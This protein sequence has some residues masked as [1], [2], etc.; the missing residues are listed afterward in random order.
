VL[1]LE[2]TTTILR[3]G[4]AHD[5][6]VNGHRY[7]SRH[8]QFL[9]LHPAFLRSCALRVPGGK[10][11]KRSKSGEESQKGHPNENKLAPN[12]LAQSANF[13]CNRAVKNCILPKAQCVIRRSVLISNR[14]QFHLLCPIHSSTSC[15]AV[16]YDS[17]ILSDSINPTYRRTSISRT[18]KAQITFPLR[19]F[20]P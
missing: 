10:S 18:K 19:H 15:H 6:Q 12:V 17:S 14:K 7:K 16:P 3:V 13:G 1:T 11:R 8:R 4:R 2:S 5:Y 9:N 20:F